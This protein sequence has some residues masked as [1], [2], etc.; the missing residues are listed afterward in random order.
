MKSLRAASATLLAASLIAGG[1][2]TG[3]ASAHSAPQSLNN[4]TLAW[5]INDEVGGGAHDGSC[6]FL[7]AGTAGNTGS[8]RPWTESD[9]FYAAQAG[10]V[11]IEKPTAAGGWQAPTWAN[12]CKDKNGTPV[13][14]IIGST[15][16]NRVV[17]TKGT[18]SVDPATG[19]ATIRWNGSF[20]VAFY[21]GMV[22]WS[23]V[24]PVLTVAVDGTG[25]L[26]ADLA[27]YASDMD[28]LDKWE[29]LT[30]DDV[31]LA[32]L[33]GV[34]VS[35]TGL[36]T[37]PKYLGVTVDVEGDDQEGV[38]QVDQ[39]STN[40]AYW[41]SFPQSFIDY[42][43]ELG[44]GPYWY[45]SGGAADVK[46]VTTSNGFSVVF[47]DPANKPV[48]ST[49]TA[50]APAKAYGQASTVNITVNARGRTATGTVTL[51]RG[52]ATLGTANLSAGRASI[53]L[54]ATALPVG[55][56]QLS[57]QYAGAGLVLP[58]TR[59]VSVTVSKAK[60]KVSQAKATKKKIKR[61]KKSSVKV[62][63]MAPGVTASGKVKVTWRGTKGK[64]KGVKVTKSKKLNK[65]GKVTI[66][67]KK[68]K[69]RGTYKLQVN[70]TGSATTSTAKKA[71]GKV[72][73]R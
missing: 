20:T 55:T 41:G 23:A 21:G 7:S 30:A 3:A 14:P 2:I 52:S 26:K 66:K 28:D 70:Y 6:N 64:A 61:K 36:V 11:R 48:A 34:S 56:H 46:K 8:V 45:T 16:G 22:Y 71:A 62:T 35:S 63:V 31:T 51:K 68:L 49:T 9:G 15:S 10:N 19:T 1:A 44:A 13:K 12:K 32:D 43:Q 73:V 29:P 37:T 65:K 59:A 40:S 5:S 47:D 33:S 39:S 17:L 38:G 50:S 24:N 25:T 54:G 60:A 72:K 53:P 4:A 42:Q 58:S 67:S 18:G 69:K 27:G 57:V